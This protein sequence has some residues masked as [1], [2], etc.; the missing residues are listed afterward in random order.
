M[1]QIPYVPEN[2]PFTA[3][4]RMWL[5]GFLAGVFSSAGGPTVDVNFTIDTWYARNIGWV[6][7]VTNVRSAAGT[8]STTDLLTGYRVGSAASDSIAPTVKRKMRFRR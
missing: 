8:T 2:A 5:N 1:T 7:V 3:T 4:Q 6:K